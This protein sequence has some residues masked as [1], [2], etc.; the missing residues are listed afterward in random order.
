MPW[1]GETKTRV[2][3]QHECD[4]ADGQALARSRVED[5][6]DVPLEAVLRNGTVPLSVLERLVDAALSH[7][8]DGLQRP[9]ASRANAWSRSPIKSSTCSI[10]V[11]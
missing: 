1:S 6:S 7:A 9:Y 4:R 8:P 2:L 5:C 3:A 11:E 10:P